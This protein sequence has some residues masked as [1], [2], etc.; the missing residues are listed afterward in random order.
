MAGVAEALWNGREVPDDCGPLLQQCREE[1]QWSLQQARVCGMFSI[2]AD[3]AF[4]LATLCDHADK[5]Q[6]AA[7]AC[8]S[9][10][11][12]ASADVQ[13]LMQATLAAE[14]RER[15]MQRLV[16]HVN[17]CGWPMDCKS[18]TAARELLQKISTA[19]QRCNVDVGDFEAVAARQGAGSILLALTSRCVGSQ[20]RSSVTLQC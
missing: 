15:V 5:K 17:D 13:V 4:E 18:S 8:L 20:V 2:A 11:L 9:Q 14:S 16:E 1:L 12:S 6:I 10:S 7:Q 19:E 3:C